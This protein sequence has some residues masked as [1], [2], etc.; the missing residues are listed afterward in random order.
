[1]KN[2]IFEVNGA[3]LERFEGNEAPTKSIES[4][5]DP[6]C[7]NKFLARKLF[8]VSRGI[9]SDLAYFL[10]KLLRRNIFKAICV[11]NGDHVT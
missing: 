6:V 3:V 8:V 2:A 11:A 4:F 1:M 5:R 9:N 10:R 7:A